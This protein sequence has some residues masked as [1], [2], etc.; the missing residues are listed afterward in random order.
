MIRADHLTKRFG[1]NHAVHD[2]TF[3]VE[4]GAVLAFL[5]RN[6]AGKT[7]TMR[8]LTCFLQPSAGSAQVG[9]HD[10]VREPL[11]VRRLIGYLPESNPIYTEMK[12]K[13]YLGYR[14][15]LKGVEKTKRKKAIGET[16]ERFGL[17]EVEG[18]VIGHLS[19]G[20]RQR[21]GFADTLTH[22]PEVLILDEPTVGLDPNQI[23]QVRKLIRDLAEK[24][25]VVI[26]THI[27]QEVEAVCD[28]VI[29]IDNGRIVLQ[30]TLENLRRGLTTTRRIRA[31]IRSTGG[32]VANSLGS[33]TGVARVEDAGGDEFIT[34]LL[35]AEQGA[36]PREAVYRL[37]VEKGWILRELRMEAR[38]L[39]EIFMEITIGRSEARGESL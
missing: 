11:A 10:V 36:D 13:E 5:G 8:I 15:A 9:G 31:E 4:K 35:E 33:V 37:A 23:Q 6:G 17:K 38:T 21:V 1:Q 16:M 30:D 32:G 2:A 3:E 12:V 34:Y 39:E 20:Y 18:K 22:D 25:T 29:I 7:T 14:A 27:L 26:S 19:R 24:R 28:R